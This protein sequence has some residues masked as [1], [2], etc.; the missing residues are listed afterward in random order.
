MRVFL[1][2]FAALIVAA[3]TGFYAWY[4]MRP[5]PAPVEAAVVEAPPKPTEVFAAASELTVGTIILPDQLE[6]MPM[7][8]SAITPEMV[9]AD[10]AGEQLLVGSVARQVLPKGVPI[11]RSGTVQPGDRGFLAAVLPE[12]MRAISIRSPRSG[13]SVASPCPATMSTSS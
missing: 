8:K 6:R 12:G 7:E 9:V 3:G 5:K 11:A 4:G 13:G 10:E 2:V 1:L